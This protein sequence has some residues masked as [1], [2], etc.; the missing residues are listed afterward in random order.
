MRSKALSYLC[1]VLIIIMSISFMGCKGDS[2]G[3]NGQP[4]VD[5]DTKTDNFYD[6]YDD[7]GNRVVLSKKLRRILSINL[8]TDELLLALADME[9]L[10]ALSHY[11]DDAGLSTMADAAKGVKVKLRD[12][13]PELIFAQNPDLVVTNNGVSK[14]IL[15]SLRDLG[16]TVFVSKTPKRIDEVFTR[17]ERLGQVIGQT[18]RAAA[19]NNKLR[20]TMDKVKSR[21]GN[22]PEQEQKVVIAL[23]FGGVVGIQGGLFDDMCRQA[24]L[25]NGGAILGLT[26]NNAVSMEQVVA[27]D[28]D[29]ILLPTW[30][31]Y[32][33]KTAEFKEKLRQDPLFKHI[34]AVKNDS[35]YVVPDY[36]RYSASHNAV[37]GV[38]ELAKTVYAERFAD[39]R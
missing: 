23:S 10:V 5:A 1:Q 18:E 34:R 8:G 9:Q 39:D 27:L 33:D 26:E 29:V 12:K 17:I 6:G 14:E 35:M 36:Y 37:L 7:V 30:S 15:D 28:P 31:A 25:R 11:V 24:G 22:I 16:L 21:V 4:T 13:S 3:G 2:V 19:L 32:G 38:Y 20:L